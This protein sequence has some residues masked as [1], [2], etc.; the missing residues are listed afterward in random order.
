MID[1]AKKEPGMI[2]VVG[3]VIKRAKLHE[4]IE[5]IIES[6][7]IKKLRSKKASNPSI[8]FRDKPIRRLTKREKKLYDSSFIPG[9]DDIT[10]EQAQKAL[11]Y[12]IVL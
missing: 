10:E 8:L 3:E 11:K 7:Y 12:G 5:G 1:Q 4:E 9:L 6:D 2:R